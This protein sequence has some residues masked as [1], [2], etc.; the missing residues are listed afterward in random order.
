VLGPLL[1]LS[2][3]LLLCYQCLLDLPLLLLASRSIPLCNQLFHLHLLNSELQKHYFKIFLLVTFEQFIGYLQFKC[4]SPS[5]LPLRKPPI[6]PPPPASMRVFPL[7]P[8]LPHCP[9]I[10]LYWGIQPPQ[11]QRLLLPLM[12]DKVSLCYICS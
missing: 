7:Q 5:W 1:H 8:P 9:S 2:T 4:H 6:L 12:P 3:C 10:P 11:D